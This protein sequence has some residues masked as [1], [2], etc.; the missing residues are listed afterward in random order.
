MYNWKTTA[1]IPRSGPPAATSSEG[2]TVQRSTK[3]K[4]S[5]H[6]AQKP[7]KAHQHNDDWGFS[8]VIGPGHFRVTELPMNFILTYSRVKHQAI[9][10]GAELWPILDHATP[11]PTIE[12]WYRQFAGD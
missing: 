8:A 9:S 5:D 11:K 2:Q 7:N 6:N 3:V 4:M 12:F 10:P 1:N